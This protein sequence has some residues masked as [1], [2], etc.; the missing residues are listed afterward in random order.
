M[1]EITEFLSSKFDVFAEK[2]IQKSVQDDNNILQ[3]HSFYRPERFGI[4]NPRGFRN[5]HR[6]R[7]SFVCTRQNCQRRRLECWRY[8][9]YSFVKNFLHSLFIQ[10]TISLNDIC[11]TQASEFYAYRAYLETLLTYGNNAANTHLTNAF[12]YLDSGNV[13]P[14]D[15]TKADSSNKGFITR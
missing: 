1:P 13:L 6:F 2:P 11:I 7:H 14:C 9:P 4:S 5:L 12:W 15:P 3:S 10:W 8:W